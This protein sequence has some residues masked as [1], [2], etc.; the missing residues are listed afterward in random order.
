M[1]SALAAAKYDRV[2]PDYEESY[3]AES[4]EPF[5]PSNT[6]LWAN[7][8]YHDQNDQPV[9]GDKA[10][11]EYND[12]SNESPK[13]PL[14]TLLRAGN[15]VIHE[16]GRML[17]LG[18]NFIQDILEGNENAPS[19]QELL[20]AAANV[21]NLPIYKYARFMLAAAREDVDDVLPE[22]LNQFV[23]DY[24]PKD[25]ISEISLEDDNVSEPELAFYK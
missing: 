1:D 23:I 8:H 3:S 19:G 6:P 2:A 12:D 16:S 17:G 5:D 25:D 9:E 7:A 18:E 11:W 14:S 13:I 15:A 24:L 21:G 22:P 10:E 4:I 20:A